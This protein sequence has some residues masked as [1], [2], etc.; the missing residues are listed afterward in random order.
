MMEI[1]NTKP[2]TT[3]RSKGSPTPPSVKNT[4]T[5]TGKSSTQEVKVRSF[6][7]ERCHPRFSFESHPPVLTQV[8]L[9]PCRGRDSVM[10]RFR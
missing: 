5:L 10:P 9:I 4:K 2:N 7:R 1:I 3:D 6:Y 8:S